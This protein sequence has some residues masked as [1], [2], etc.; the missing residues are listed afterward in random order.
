ML[1]SSLQLKKIKGCQL[2][3]VF[4]IFTDWYTL[5]LYITSSGG[6]EKYIEFSMISIEHWLIIVPSGS[7]LD[8]GAQSTF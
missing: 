3:V 8:I 7:E 2:Y 4:K 6:P 1:I 5:A